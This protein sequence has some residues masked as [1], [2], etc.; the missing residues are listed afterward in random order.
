[1]KLNI[2]KV[3]IYH[4]QNIFY[5]PGYFSQIYCITFLT[6]KLN[7]QKEFMIQQKHICAFCNPGRAERHDLLSVVI[8][9]IKQMLF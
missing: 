1:M 9:I 4:E 5:H 8:N 3:Y 6:A 2:F 7:F